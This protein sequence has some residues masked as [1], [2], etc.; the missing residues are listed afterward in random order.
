MKDNY[1]IS[2]IGTHTVDDE[3]DTIELT[4]SAS[5]IEKNGKKLIKYKQYDPDN[6]GDYLTNIIKIESKDR[7][8]L[9]K[10]HKGSISQLILESGKRHQCLYDTPVGSMS[11][12]IYADTVFFDIDENGGKVEIDY[13]IDFNADFHSDNHLE[14]ILVKKE[15]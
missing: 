12:G 1:T 14:I 8:T 2:V 15:N 6:S 4:T 7:I 5:Y 10:N 13:T 3:K 9:T 11:I